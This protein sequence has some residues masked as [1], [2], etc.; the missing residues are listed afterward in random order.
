M[1]EQTSTSPDTW[2][3]TSGLA[4]SLTHPRLIAILNLT[5]DSFSD[6]GRLDTPADAVHTAHHAALA[7]ADALDIGGESTRPGAR[8]VSA[9]EQIARVVP[10]IKAIRAEGGILGTIPISI[11]TTLAP[12]AHAAL[13]AGAHIINDV[14]G[15]TEDPAILSLAA[16]T[17]AGL[18]LMHRVLA[19]DQDR[20]STSYTPSEAP[21][22][23]DVV[24]HVLQGL[25][26]LMQRAVDAGVDPQRIVLDP[27]LGFGK[28]VDQN[29]MLI[30]R[31]SELLTL[32]RPILS[33]LSRKSFVGAFA[34]DPP[35]PTDQRLPAT[36]ACSIAHYHAG[37]RLFRV[38]DVAAHTQALR[39]ARRL[40]Q[41]NP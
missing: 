38:H 28:T 11:D 6:G 2:P 14:S 34:A 18:I 25:R 19:P 23:G 36:L 15:A 31:T 41:P 27:G 21:I 17:K 35:L 9:E 8:R 29:A 3:L 40:T 7:G 24:E 30:R 32:G 22:R 12:V 39:I 5:P 10:A 20:Y 33:A 4:I 1:P 26:A 37:A 16:S 13:D